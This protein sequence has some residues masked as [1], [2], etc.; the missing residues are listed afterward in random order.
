MSDC[1]TRAWATPE[2]EW[3]ELSDGRLVCVS[4]GNEPHVVE[5]RMRSGGTP[6][7]WTFESPE[8]DSVDEMRLDGVRMVEAP[9]YE[10][11]CEVRE[12]DG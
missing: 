4:E 11:A 12:I 3:R 9:M 5:L 8:G 2:M 1:S 6:K 10:E 7:T